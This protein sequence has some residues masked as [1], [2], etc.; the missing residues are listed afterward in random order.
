[1]TINGELRQIRGTIPIGVEWT[2]AMTTIM[3]MIMSTDMS[4]DMKLRMMTTMMSTGG[5]MEVLL[6]EEDDNLVHIIRHEFK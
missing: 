4:I 2:A 3:T 1:M 5:L 6:R